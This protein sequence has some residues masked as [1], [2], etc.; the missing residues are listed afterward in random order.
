[1]Y[2]APFRGHEMH[3]NRLFRP[4]EILHR[5]K[6]VTWNF[7]A[8]LLLTGEHCTAHNACG[9]RSAALEF[10]GVSASMFISRHPPKHPVSVPD[11]LRPLLALVFNPLVADLQIPR[12]PRHLPLSLREQ[13]PAAW[14]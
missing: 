11:Y 5:S 9:Q 14:I 2:E 10:R 8:E 12:T 1:M 6:F 7:G 3:Q 13:G 4:Q